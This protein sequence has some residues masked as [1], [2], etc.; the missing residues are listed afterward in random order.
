MTTAGHGRSGAIQFTGEVLGLRRAGDY[1]VLTLTAGGIPELARPGHFVALSVGGRETSM[2]LRRAFSIYSVQSRGVYG[3][4]LEIVFATR[5]KGTEWL[6]RLHRHDPVD[7]VGPLG[8]PFAL[9]KEPVPCVLVAGGYGS[10]P[11][12]SL[13]DAL[14]ARGCRVDVVLGA[15]TES[16]LFG[17]LDA[18]RIAASLTLTTDDGSLGERG[19]VTDALPAVMQRTD[20]DVVYACGPMPML[21]AVAKVATEYG[22]YSQC[23]VEESMACGIGVCMTCV[24]PVIGDDG[25]TRM[26]RSCVDGPVFR[27]DRVRW[28]DIGT[29]PEDTLGAPVSGGH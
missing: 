9:P 27:G 4:T 22:A 23:A 19:M 25:V 14:R 6:S 21:R 24:L 18:K 29:I 8:R 26:L 20:A 28:D 16:K 7:I 17:V 5:G 12:F 13:A 1:H 3:G 10:A 11:M 2:L 15:S